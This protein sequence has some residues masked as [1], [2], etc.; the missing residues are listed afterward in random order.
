M[1]DPIVPVATE[2]QEE[3]AEVARPQV[4]PM[5]QRFMNMIMPR[6]IRPMAQ[7]VAIP[8]VE[9]LAASA[10]PPPP[11]VQATVSLP[12]EQVY[13][14]WRRAVE[15]DPIIVGIRQNRISISQERRMPNPRAYER[16]L[17]EQERQLSAQYASRIRQIRDQLEQQY[18]QMR[19]Y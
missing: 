6:R 19:R 4:A 15:I 16:Q 5:Y 12:P 1:S 9:E 14:M 8:T 17:L 2:L 11:P 18:G 7:A 13:L 3:E 10:Q